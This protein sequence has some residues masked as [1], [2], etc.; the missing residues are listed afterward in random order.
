M[1]VQIVLKLVSI[2]TNG[3]EKNLDILFI[4]DNHQLFQVLKD[5]FSFVGHYLFYAKNT[6]KAFCVLQEEDIDIILLDV[7]LGNEN[8][9]DTL[10]KLKAAYPF[11]PVIMITGYATV[12]AAV[13]AMKLGAFDFVRKPIDFNTLCTRIDSATENLLRKRKNEK[14]RFNT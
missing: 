6:Q 7:K 1:F 9:V 5:N 10:E 4:D 3:R 2:C 11:I 8:G 13:R 14:I 12:E